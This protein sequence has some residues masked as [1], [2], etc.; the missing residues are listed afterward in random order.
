MTT[1]VVMTIV[2]GL[3]TS[4]SIT[5]GDILSSHCR[6]LVLP[7]VNV[8]ST[9]GACGAENGDWVGKSVGDKTGDVG[10][11]EGDSVGAS[12]GDVVGNPGGGINIPQAK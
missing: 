4:V 1:G 5:Q 9:T 3:I 6:Q 11:S 12:E 8:S 2:I 10:S 7:Q